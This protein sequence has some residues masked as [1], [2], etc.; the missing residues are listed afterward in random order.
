MRLAV[1]HQDLDPGVRMTVTHHVD[2]VALL[3]ASAIAPDHPRRDAQ[4]AQHQRQRR[5]V[6]LAVALFEIDQEVHHRIDVPI[7]RVISSVYVNSP[8]SAR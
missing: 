5:R 3:V 4:R 1:R 6:T 8:E 7:L 2:A